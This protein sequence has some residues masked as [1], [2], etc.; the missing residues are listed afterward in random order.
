MEAVPLELEDDNI[1]FYALRFDKYFGSESFLTLEGGDASVEGPVFQTG[2]G[3]VQLIEVSRPWL[4]LNYYH[5]RFNVAASR[6][7][8]DAPKQLALSSGNNLALD[9]E[10]TALEV[11]GH[12]DWDTTRLVVGASWEKDEIDSTDPQ[13]GQQTLIFQPIDVDSS[14]LF[15]QLDWDLSDK[16]RLVL[17]GRVDEGD[18]F[19]T[20]FNPK[21]AIVWAVNPKN[22]LR[23]T[24]NEA[25]Q[26]ANYS[27]FFLDVNVGAFPGAALEG[28]ACLP[29]QGAPCGFPDLVP[30]KAL[31]NATLDVE[32]IATFEIGYSGIL[33]KNTLLTVDL[34]TA[35]SSEFITDLLP[36]LTAAGFTNPNF[37]PFAGV[38][39][40]T[41][42]TLNGVVGMFIPGAAVTNNVDGSPIIAAVSYSNFGDVD[43]NGLDLGLTSQFADNWTLN[44]TY[45]YFD[46]DIQR[47]LPGFENLL[48]P[49]T[50]EN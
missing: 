7:D 5:P 46:F 20:Q 30:V 3:R 31:G 24:Y 45:S 28:F 38:S 23:F 13:T 34:Y 17:A 16:V 41:A 48:V 18:L 29:T 15:A 6:N 35:E 22:T 9:S 21:G 32:E 49:N 11:Q 4:R 8:R 36:Q 12:W 26:V 27:E 33:G 37:G 25:F 42:A 43:T 1:N 47:D 44:F 14:A 39:A 10:N 40:L 2:I 50:P 19:D